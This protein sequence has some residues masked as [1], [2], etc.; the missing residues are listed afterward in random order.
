[1]ELLKNSKYNVRDYLLSI[2]DLN[3]PRVVDMMD[4]KINKMNSAAVMIARL[5]LMRKAIYPDQPDIGIDIRGRYR[6]AFTDEL[7]ELEKDLQDQITTYLPEFLPV[8]VSCVYQRINK[9]NCVV[10]YIAIQHIAYQ[11]VYNTE[12]MTLEGF[13]DMM[14][15]D[16]K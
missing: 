9:V 4:I 16:L 10:I 6:F 15:G 5:L 3:R 2:D 11:L 8:E 14:K 13:E 12:D 7:R 1:M